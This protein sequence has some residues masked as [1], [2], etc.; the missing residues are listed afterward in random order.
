M[1]DIKLKNVYNGQESNGQYNRTN[2]NGDTK[3]DMNEST[4]TSSQEDLK[5][6]QHDSILKR[7]PENSEATTVLVGAVEFL[8]QP[9]IGVF[10]LNNF[11]EYQNCNF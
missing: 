5:R 8:E 7:I 6:L 9:T 11:I 4:Y 3:I 1:N 10:N 2:S